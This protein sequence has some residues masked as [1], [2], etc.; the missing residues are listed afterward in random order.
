MCNTNL[1][2]LYRL[3][4]NKKQD[5]LITLN[6]EQIQLLSN[7]YF[8]R[9]ILNI[10]CDVKKQKKITC[11][12]ISKIDMD[13][14]KKDLSELV[15]KYQSLKLSKLDEM[16]KFYFEE[17]SNLLEKHA[18]NKIVKITIRD[19]PEWYGQ[20]HLELKR[21]ARKYEKLY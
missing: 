10:K 2:T 11:R 21:L 6:P 17:L 12:N 4:T 8:V 13:L 19:K 14:L 16:Y 1:Q 5:D 18:P 20:E 15:V 7:H 3:N 9:G